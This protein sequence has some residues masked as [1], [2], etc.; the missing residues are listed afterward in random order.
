MYPSGKMLLSACIVIAAG[1]C[2]PPAA[3]AGTY[4]DLRSAVETEN[5]PDIAR[6]LARGADPDTP[7]ERG[8]TLLMVAIRHKN[9]RL[10]DLLIDAGA[11]LNLR[12][13]HGETAI[14]LASYGGLYDVVKKL[15]LRGAEVNH[16]G[17]NPLL[18][19]AT[20]GHPKIVRLLLEGGVPVD[21]ASDNGTTALM[22]AARGNHSDTVRVLLEHGADP[23]LH[24]EL[25]GTALQ[26]ALAKEYHGTAELLRQNGA[27]D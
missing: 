12:N 13:R 15:Y 10:V 25:G 18:Y 7:D 20:S 2:A 8:N 6:L 26:W 14:M 27:R 17:W 4:E 5:L 16:P 23:N 22:M 21:A 11:R 1:V 3:T 24:N 19:A 9:T